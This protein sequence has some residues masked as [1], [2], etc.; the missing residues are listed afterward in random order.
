MN[1]GP[2]SP[3]ENPHLAG[4]EKAERTLLQ[5]YNSGRL[6]HAWLITGPPGIGKATLAFRF[7]RFVLARAHADGGLFAAAPSTPESLAVEASDPVFRR[8]AAAG[9]ADLK[10]V[11]REPDPK[12]GKMRTEIVAGQVR[13]IGR[14]L[15]LTA[16]E[17]GWR[18]VLIDSGDDMNHHAANAVLKVL[19]EPPTR[20]LLLVVSHTPGRLLPT[21][22]S[23]CRRLVLKPLAGGT[24]AELVSR[25]RPEAGNVDLLARL[26]SGSVGRA[27]SLAEEGGLAL[28]H[29]LMGL[30]ETLPELDTG[31]L[32]G[33]GDRAAKSDTAFHALSDLLR[34]WLGRLIIFAAD[35]EM[36]RP[37]PDA[38]PGEAA[39]MERLSSGGLERWLEVWEKVNPLLARADKLDRKQVVLN[40]FF[41]ME[42]ALRS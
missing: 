38:D 18:V 29:D 28:Y 20:S 15:G 27:L 24:V 33:L 13:G 2:P 8:I 25:Y 16:A 11:E 14:F 6:P 36:E 7:A 23:R 26:A 34:G 32:H 9:H 21:I 3:R 12:T 19:E 37:A 1:D 10:C 40:V 5:A 22:R 31:A 41:T 30:L 39:L 17:G 42:S 35:G 4:H